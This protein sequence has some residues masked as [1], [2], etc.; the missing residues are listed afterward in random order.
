MKHVK[1]PTNQQTLVIKLGA[2]GDMVQAMPMFDA[3]CQQY[4]DTLTLLTTAPFLEFAQ[5]SGYFKTIICDDRASLKKNL[6]VL[7]KLR[8][9]NFTRIIDLQNVDRTRLYRLLLMGRFGQWITDPYKQNDVHPSKRFSALCTAQGWPFVSTI[10]I[11]M[12]AEPFS[13]IPKKPYVLIVAGASNAHGGKKRWPQKNYAAVCQR[14]LN[15]GITPVLIG[16]NTDNLYELETFCANTDTINLI[17]R[18]TL[19]QLIMVA[20]DAIGALGNDTGPQL[21]IA[22]A[23]CPT[24]TLFSAVNP[25]NKGGAWPWDESRHKNI[26]VD[27]LANLSIDTVWDVLQP[28]LD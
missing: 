11:E 13:L 7:S 21:I 3:L 15:A 18:T 26:Y 28:L 25:P 1:M 20:K 12:M 23:G 19:F 24:I 16:S 10:N 22:A 5:R 14:L 27:D 2:L 4:G 9:Q 17:G 6:A 8:K